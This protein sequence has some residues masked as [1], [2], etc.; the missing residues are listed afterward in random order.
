GSGV[1]VNRFAHMFADVGVR[2]FFV[3]SGFL[4]TTLLLRERE[5]RGEISLRG[6]YT[7]R[8]LRI[9]PAFYSYL[10]VAALLAAVGWID[11]S[12]KDLAVAATYTTNFQ[13]VRPWHLGTCGRSRSRS[14]S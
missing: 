7:R 8:A 3:I 13:V 10:I 6:F 1:F 12:G 11:A 9:F 4:I 14:S 5:K 2:T